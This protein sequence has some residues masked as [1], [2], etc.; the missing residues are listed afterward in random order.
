M[1]K[2]FYFFIFLF[3]PLGVFAIG[4]MDSIAPPPNPSAAYCEGLGYEFAIQE[5]PEGQ[6]GICRVAEGVDVPAWSFLRGEDAQEYSYCAKA[7]Y[8]MKLIDDPKRCGVAYKP[9]HGCLACILPDGSAPEV[10]NL[11]KIEKIKNTSLSKKNDQICKIDGVCVGGENAQNCAQDCIVQP[12]K[13][14]NLKYIFWGI[15]VITVVIAG[16]IV[17]KLTRNKDNQI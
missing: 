6:L 8:E 9:N 12:E 10:S 17:F 15:I 11:M 2:I 1:R 3:L 16:S 14:I 13:E 7:G 5:T 4:P